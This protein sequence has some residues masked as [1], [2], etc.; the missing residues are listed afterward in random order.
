MRLLVA[1]DYTP[2]R[3]SLVQGL[4][5]AGFAVDATGDGDEAL[6]YAE[7]NEYDVIVLDLMLPGRD[8]LA[9]LEHLRKEHNPAHVLVLTAKDTVADRVRGL[10]QGADDYMVKPFAFAELL[11]RIHSLVRR[12]YDAK[13]PVIRVGD[14][15]IDTRTRAVHCGD[16]RF[17]L[18]AREYL[19]LEY[20]A[21]RLNQV[22]TRIEIWEHLYDFNAEPNS[23]VIDVHIGKLRRKLEEGGRQRLIHTRRGLGYEL[24]EKP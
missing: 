1:E 23:N 5:E 13:S 6:W 22:V 19:L 10:E 7:S 4:E 20:L 17:D 12:R 9:I 2:L 15:R 21:L 24:T 16:Y 11:A 3:T 18:T 14:L 8:G